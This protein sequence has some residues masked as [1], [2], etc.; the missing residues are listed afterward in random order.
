MTQQFMIQK[1]CYKMY[2][3][4]CANTC[5]DVTVLQFM[6]CLEIQNIEY[7]ENGA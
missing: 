3:L 1:I 6:E 7:L 2:P 5:R 4:L